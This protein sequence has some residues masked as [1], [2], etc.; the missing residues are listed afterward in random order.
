V[1]RYQA[2][3]HR[4]AYLVTGQ[5]ADAEDAAQT[6]FLKAY[7]A[8]A[9]FDPGRPFRPWLLRIVVNEAKNRRRWRGR[10]P[11][12]ELEVAR[13]PA[14]AEPSPEELAVA[15]E[16]R[17]ALLRAVN[18]LRE[19]DRLAIACRFFLELSEAETA[20]ALGVAPGTVKSRLSRAL[21]RLRAALAREGIPG[22]EPEAIHE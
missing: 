13:A 5:A 22:A 1:R 21:A 15:E 8:L 17:A 6:A 11:E 18:G 12:L 20:E 4:T 7:S 9:R 3:A 10:H 19:G 2:L 14:A 16:R